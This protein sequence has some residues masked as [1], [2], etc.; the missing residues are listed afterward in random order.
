M[1]A[2]NIKLNDEDIAMLAKM[3]YGEAAG[4]D[5]D[6]M[7]M[8]T[9]TAVNRLRSGRTKEFG[10]NLRR[11]LEKGYYAVSNP[12]QPYKE[13]LSGVFQSDISKKK[14]AQ[15]MK[16]VNDVI[17]KQDYGNAMFYF[18]DNEMQKLKN[19]GKFNFSMVIP[20]GKIGAYNTFYYP[21][22][23]GHYKRF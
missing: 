18:T 2:K 11:V 20:S 1:P 21:E 15:A 7:K 19:Q 12:N 8:I 14:W 4:A 16:A 23:I 6:T 17:T 22:K 10:G 9:Q 5:Y 3:V 13:A